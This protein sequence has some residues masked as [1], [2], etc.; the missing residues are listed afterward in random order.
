MDQNPPE[1]TKRPGSRAE[2]LDRMARRGDGLRT[3]I[4][5]DVL[6]ARNRARNAFDLRRQIARHPFV[7]AAIVIGGVLVATGIGRSLLRGVRSSFG[8]T[9]RA[10]LQKARTRLRGGT[11]RG[12]GTREADP[13]GG[14]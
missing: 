12:P 3:A 9:R 13:K 5:W 7:A 8:P 6:D 1:V 10:G 11:G 4:G 2:E 14:M